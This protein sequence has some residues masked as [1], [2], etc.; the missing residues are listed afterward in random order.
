LCAPFNALL[1]PALETIVKNLNFFKFRY[2]NNLV[3]LGCGSL[4]FA[5]YF[6]DFCLFFCQFLSLGY[7]EKSKILIIC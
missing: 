6:F 3:L 1:K 2:T 5:F 4:N 7:L